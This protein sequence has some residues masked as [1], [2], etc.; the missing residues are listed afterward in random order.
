MSIIAIGLDEYIVTK[1]RNDGWTD[2]TQETIKI[3]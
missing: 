3:I 1:L 2:L